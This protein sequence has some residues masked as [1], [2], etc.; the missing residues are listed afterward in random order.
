MKSRRIACLLGVALSVLAGCASSATQTASR[1]DVGVQDSSSDRLGATLF[2]E[3][4]VQHTLWARI[5]PA[6]TDRA[7]ASGETESGR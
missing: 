7:L 2:R 3:Q 1:L 6:Y 4:N 5:D